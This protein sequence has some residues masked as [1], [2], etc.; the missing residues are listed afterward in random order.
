MSKRR[1]NKSAAKVVQKQLA[2][3]R[4]RKRTMWTSIAA[5]AV[6]VIAGLIGWGVW[7]SQRSDAGPLVAPATATTTTGP[8]IGTGPVNIQLYEDFICPHCKDFENTSGSAINE[9]VSDGKAKVTYNTLA[10]QWIEPADP[11]DIIS[12]QLDADGLLGV[13]RED[14]D[15]ITAHAEG[16][17]LE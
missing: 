8:T 6:L 9:L 2:A 7:Q 1:E 12:K 4:R 16:A 5:V 3:E 13:R 17:L 11:L 15:R 14:L 10:R